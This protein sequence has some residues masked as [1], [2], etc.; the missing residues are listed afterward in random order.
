MIKRQTGTA[1]SPAP[2]AAASLIEHLRS[3]PA[4]TFFYNGILASQL[5]SYVKTSPKEH[6]ELYAERSPLPGIAALKMPL[7]A[8]HGTAD[9]IV[10]MEQACSLYQ[11]LVAGGRRVEESWISPKGDVYQPATS[12][13]PQA[14]AVQPA[15]R[16]ATPTRFVF[17]EG[18]GHFYAKQP[19]RTATEMVLSFLVQELRP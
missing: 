18:Q 10:P 5:Q 14:A 1:A 7:L 4:Q 19:K 3:H 16:V 2:V 8:F 13:C 12:A 15:T 11:M 17:M 9:H 6:P